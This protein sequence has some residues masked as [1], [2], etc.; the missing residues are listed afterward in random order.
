MLTLNASETR[1]HVLLLIGAFYDF[2]HLEDT[3]N[4]V[5][6]IVSHIEHVLYSVVCLRDI[7]LILTFFKCCMIKENSCFSF[8]TSLLL[9]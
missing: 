2:S 3:A 5:S 4:G 1:I 7:I 6:T 8:C 9:A